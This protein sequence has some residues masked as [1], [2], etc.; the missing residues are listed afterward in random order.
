MSL[1][2][3]QDNQQDFSR[4]VFQSADAMSA[5]EIEGLFEEWADCLK[6]IY[7]TKMDADDVDAAYIIGDMINFFK[8]VNVDD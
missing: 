5:S 6:I 2:L 7:D 4:E 1:H 8:S 3:S